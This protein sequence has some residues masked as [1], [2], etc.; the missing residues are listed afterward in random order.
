MNWRN[1]SKIWLNG[2][3]QRVLFYLKNLLLDNS[4]YIFN[5]ILLSQ[6]A[7]LYHNIFLY[8]WKSILIHFICIL[9]C[10]EVFWVKNQTNS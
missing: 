10:K 1:T 3:G 4:L 6:E 7:F 9:K 8:I 5:E 2:L